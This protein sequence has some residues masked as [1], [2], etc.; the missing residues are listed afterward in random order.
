MITF[1]EE[2]LRPIDCNTTKHSL[3]NWSYFPTDNI[4]H[5]HIK[6]CPLFLENTVPF[7]NFFRT[8]SFFS[9]DC[10]RSKWRGIQ[11]SASEC[12]EKGKG[13]IIFF[14]YCQRKKKMFRFANLSFGEKRNTRSRKSKW[15]RTKKS[16]FLSASSTS[17]L[18]L[19]SRIRLVSK[20]CLGFWWEF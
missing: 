11:S 20:T 13:W 18:I 9:V 17:K 10:D 7:Y 1:I 5:D 8:K 4:N 3:E 12:V 6:R 14:W 2:T 19:K 15:M 16:A